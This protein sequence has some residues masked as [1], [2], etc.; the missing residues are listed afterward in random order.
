MKT[1]FFIFSG[2][3]LLALLI[4]VSIKNSSTTT[5]NIEDQTPEASSCPVQTTGDDANA[6]ANDNLSFSKCA[7]R[8]DC[9]A[10]VIYVYDGDTVLISTNERVRYIGVDSTEVQHGNLKAQCFSKEATD[11]NTDLVG[12]KEVELI[13]DVSDKDKYGRLLR[14]VYIDN[15]FVNDY[16]AR[17]GFAYAWTVP[18]DV[19]FSEE[20][21]A[22]QSEARANQRG[23][24]A[25]GVCH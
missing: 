20:F 3:A 10:W 1:L 5:I 13:K 25:A 9:R 23:L 16:L 14:Y 11:K 7:G 15:I 8:A 22:A 12:D 2:L 17:N 24:W 21:K 18:P 6:N 19:K 4:F